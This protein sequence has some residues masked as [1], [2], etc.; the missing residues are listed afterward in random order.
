MRRVASSVPSSEPPPPASFM[1]SGQT[2]ITPLARKRA[3]SARLFKMN[4][5]MGEKT[6]GSGPGGPE[7][8]SILPHQPLQEPQ[9]HHPR[10]DS[11]YRVAPAR[12]G[13]DRDHAGDPARVG[14][15][16]VEAGGGEQ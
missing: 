12:A 3:T 10:A 14:P 16:E 2:S 1:I 6:L 4:S 5:P 13:H 7:K 9:R 11:R 15:G 8:T